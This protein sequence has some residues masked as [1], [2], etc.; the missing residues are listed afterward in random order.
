MSFQPSAAAVEVVKRELCKHYNEW[1]DGRILWESPQD[2]QAEIDEFTD[3]AELVVY[4]VH[5]VLEQQI[6]AQVAQEILDAKGTDEWPTPEDAGLELAAN[7][8]LGKA[9]P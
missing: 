6:R 8:A 7:I 9:Q 1:E 2:L 4:A 3:E 5:P